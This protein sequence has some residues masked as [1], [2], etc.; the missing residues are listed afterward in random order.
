MARS[1]KGMGHVVRSCK[2]MEVRRRASVKSAARK[3][4]GQP[5]EYN[6]RND[7]YVD[8]EPHRPSRDWMWWVFAI[9]M[10]ALL[11]IAGWRKANE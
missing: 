10:I 1:R 5:F 2:K 9:A 11:I 7:N 3:R 8:F 4:T 6:E